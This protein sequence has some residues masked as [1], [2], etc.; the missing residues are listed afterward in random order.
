MSER[1]ERKLRELLVSG[2][3]LSAEAESRAFLAQGRDRIPFSEA[4]AKVEAVPRPELLATSAKPT[5]F[6][7]WTSTRPTATP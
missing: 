6:P 3:L 2:G 4:L 7:Q 5:A 1:A